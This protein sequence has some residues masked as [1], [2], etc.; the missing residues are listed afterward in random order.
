[1]GGFT[2]HSDGRAIVLELNYRE[3]P[4]Q[5]VNVYMSAKGPAKEYRP[6]LQWPRP[7]VACDSKIVLM[8][9]DF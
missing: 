1:M 6:F 7:H 9:A 8:G 3:I 4:M 5:A 2:H